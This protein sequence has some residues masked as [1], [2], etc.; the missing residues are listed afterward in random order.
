LW[1]K[2]ASKMSRHDDSKNWNSSGAR[3]SSGNRDMC[4]GLFYNNYKPSGRE[5]ALCPPYVLPN[6]P[7]AGDRRH[8]ACHG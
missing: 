1:G 2:R 6:D 3:S 7:Y 4:S 8:P 5:D